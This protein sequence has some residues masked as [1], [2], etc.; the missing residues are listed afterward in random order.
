VKRILI[1]ATTLVALIVPGRIAGAEDPLQTEQLSPPSQSF[2]DY[3]GTQIPES[4]L[5]TPIAWLNSR[6]LTMLDWGLFRAQKTLDE[7]VADYNHDED[8]AVKFEEWKLANKDYVTSHHID[9][10]EGNPISGTG[11]KINFAWTDYD[12]KR[13]RI[14]LGFQ[15]GLAVT[16][17][18]DMRT[19]AQLLTTDACVELMKDITHYVMQK[20]SFR[21]ASEQARMA[22]DAVAGW[23]S[24]RFNSVRQPPGLFYRLAQLT[25]IDIRLDQFESSPP[26]IEC[27][28][29]FMGGPITSIFNHAPVASGLP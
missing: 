7:V 28:S 8:R 27:T 19:D 9:K 24:Q 6:P 10:I 25:E 18:G 2:Y 14:E 3:D 16:W 23:F 11:Y 17:L 21:G 4:Q 22:E 5:P 15:I 20:S 1:T 29:P 13:A 26:N 12:V